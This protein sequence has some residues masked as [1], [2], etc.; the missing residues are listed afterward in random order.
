MVAPQMAKV[1]QGNCQTVEVEMQKAYVLRY[2]LYID[3]TRPWM[4]ALYLNEW[5]SD[6]LRSSH[7]YSGKLDYL[8]Q[9]QALLG[10]TDDNFPDAVRLG[11]FQHAQSKAL[12]LISKDPLNGV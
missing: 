5:G 11:L 1:K 4:W 2:I 9:S 6:S 8:S 7:C 10:R 12:F 3:R